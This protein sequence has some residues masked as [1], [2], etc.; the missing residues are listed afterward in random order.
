MS[1]PGQ[2]ELTAALERVG[3]HAD[4]R[5]MTVALAAVERVACRMVSF[6]TD[7]VWDELTAHEANTHDGRALGNV[8]KRAVKHGVCE[9]T[10]QYRP[11]RRP[12]CH[13]RPVK[14]W[15]STVGH[16]TF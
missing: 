4:E 1:E 14:V 5:W 3:D 11:S 2:L 9:R 13:Q 10:D 8:I 16:I 12:E 6:T 7:D 15:R